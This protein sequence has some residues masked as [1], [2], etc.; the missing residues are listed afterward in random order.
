MITTLKKIW[1]LFAPQEQRKAILVLLLVTLMAATEILSVVSIVPFLSALSDPT[2]A[3]Q[4]PWLR[5]L[6]RISPIKDTAAFVA[7][8]GSL[9]MF[10]VVLTSAFKAVTFHVINRFVQMQRH[11]LSTRLLD[12]YLNQ[13]YE[14]FLTRNTSALTKNVLSEVDQLTFDVLH[15]LAMLV[16]QGAVVGAML[17]LIV[18]YDPI[19]ALSI[20]SAVFALYGTIFILAR[21]RLSRLGSQRQVAN[22]GRYKT[23]NEALSGIKDVKVTHS[24]PQWLNLFSTSSREFARHT[25][26]AETLSTTPLFIVEALGYSGLI[27]ISLVLLS[28]GSGLADVLPTLGLYGFAAYRLLPAVQI[29]Y[30]GLARLRF[31]STVLSSM[32]SD[33]LLPNERVAQNSGTL[34]P[35]RKIELRNV[36]YAYPGSTDR[37]VLDGVDLLIPANS[38]LGIAGRS[39]AGKSTLMDI[40][41]GLLSPQQGALCVDGVPITSQNLTAWQR[42]IGYVPQSIYLSDASVAENIAFGVPKGDIDLKAVERAAKTA[43]IHDFVQSELPQGYETRIG[44]RGIRLSGGQRQRVGIA[45]ALYRDPQV[46]CLDEATSAMDPETEAAFNDAIHAI[47]KRKT[48]VVIAHRESSLRICDRVVTLGAKE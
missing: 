19:M 5:A 42:T 22:A 36:Y 45:R 1:G 32:H 21:H 38:S 40:I 27:A 20:I 29:M 26:T 17:T 8:L 24:A 12:R 28:R 48:V 7:M 11:S 9:S 41:L 6:Y 39:G 35:E 4:H 10:A 34:A 16:A 18:T 30:R 43:Q 15:P 46:L 3:D 25:A 44:D 14:F 13:P 37:P 47:A 33:L 23:C 31:S 2:S